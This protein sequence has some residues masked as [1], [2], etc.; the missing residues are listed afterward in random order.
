MKLHSNKTVL[1]ARDV[2]FPRERRARQRR[3]E[4]HELSARQSVPTQPYAQ[5]PSRQP[6]I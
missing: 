1:A 2:S 5:Q 3:A 6:I 4:V